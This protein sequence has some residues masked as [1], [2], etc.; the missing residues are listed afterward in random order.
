M[1]TDSI[2]NFRLRSDAEK[3]ARLRRRFFMLT[4]GTLFALGA[5]AGFAIGTHAAMGR[6]ISQSV[7]LSE[8]FAASWLDKEGQKENAYR[9][10]MLQKGE[11]GCQASIVLPELKTEPAASAKQNKIGD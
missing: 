5:A 2:G 1:P 11:K 6:V 10:L 9:L 3:A 4:A 8:S 7:V